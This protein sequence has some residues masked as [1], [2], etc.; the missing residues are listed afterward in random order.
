M[1]P[2]VVLSFFVTEMTRLYILAGDWTPLPGDE[3]ILIDRQS[4]CLRQS[5]F[6]IMSI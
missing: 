3:C 2:K 5:L 4:G 6:A 1:L